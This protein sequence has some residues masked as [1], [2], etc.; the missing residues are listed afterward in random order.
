MNFKTLKKFKNEQHCSAIRSNT[1]PVQQAFHSVLYSIP[2]RLIWK[3]VLVQL[4]KLCL[5]LNISDLPS[6][7]FQPQKIPPFQSFKL[8]WK[9]KLLF[10]S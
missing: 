9:F 3:I 7:F 4:N 2:I 8:V 5:I 10:L 6:M 1:V